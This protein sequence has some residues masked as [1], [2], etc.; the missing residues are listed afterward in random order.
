MDTT[1]PTLLSSAWR[2]RWLVLVVAAFVVAIG[3]IY[4]LVRPAED[5]Y[6]AEATL[7][8][9]E[10]LLTDVVASAQLN[11]AQFFGSQLEILRSPLVASAAAELVTQAGIDT[12]ADD[13]AGAVTI[14]GSADSPLVGIEA[15]ASTPE[16][17]VLYVNSTADG[18]REVSV[19]Q[20]TATSVAQLA[21]IDL[22]V[23]AIDQRLAEIEAAIA[24]LLVG[25]ASLVQLQQQAEGAVAEIARLQAILSTA[26]QLEAP[27]I[28]ARIDD[29]R[30][31][32]EIYDEVRLTAVSPG[33][34]ALVE[35]QAR[36]VERRAA[37]LTLR[38]EVA[39]D[40]GS[41]PDAVALVQSA[42]VAE[43]VQGIGLAR[44][45]AVT[46]IL[47]LAAGVGLAY[48]LSVWRRRFTNRSEPEAVLGAPL[49]A[50]VPDFELEGL[51]SVV[52]A[53]DHPRSAAAEAYRF[54]SSSADAAARS[55]GIRSI[56]LASSTLGHG[57]TTT[58]VNMAIAA[59]V[60]GRSVMVLD[61]DFGNQQASRLLLGA[62]HSGRTGIT[63]VIDGVSV[64]SDAAYRI[65]IGND[66]SL[67]T[68]GRGTRPSLAATALQSPQARRLF[69]DLVDAYELV[70]IDGPPLLQVA[71]ASTLAELAEGIV[72]VVEHQASHPEIVELGE[73]LELIGTPLLGY[74]YNRSPLRRE[75]TMSEGSMMDILGEAEPV[76]VA[77]SARPRRG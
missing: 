2:Y 6:V 47:G 8:I 13:M 15:F 24:D 36:Q 31:A 77:A 18:Y 71:Y 58:V 39:V 10:P 26:D 32:I 62:P 54:A 41:A 35:E 5:V 9:Q 52:P 74:V 23:E 53:W 29:Q 34:R 20:V 56:F 45:L 38:D 69:A 72:A 63:D 33:Q 37:L 14:I 43:P 17:A 75:M 1:E 3:L 28:R 49:L 16:L 40:S 66:V 27:V 11:N 21:R 61:C 59:A 70:F 44:L 12:T 55:R 51:E 50:D 64:L 7:V 4:Q 65:E 19:R 60:N 30:R 46:L 73:R 67:D 48:L 22:Q 68:M 25:D 42:G 57:K 76:D